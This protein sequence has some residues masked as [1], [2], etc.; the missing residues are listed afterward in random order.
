VGFTPSPRLTRAASGT[1]FCRTP[2]GEGRTAVSLLTSSAVTALYKGDDY[3][4]PRLSRMRSGCASSHRRR[5]SLDRRPWLIATQAGQDFLGHD[6][7]SDCHVILSCLL[8][9]KPMGAYLDCAIAG[10]RVH[11]IPVVEEFDLVLRYLDCS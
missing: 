1:T 6:Q 2:S 7:R 11:R 9:V 3:G 10:N 8:L 5:L 4:S